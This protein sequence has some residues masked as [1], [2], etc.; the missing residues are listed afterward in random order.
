ME[1][2]RKRVA[3]GRLHRSRTVRVPSCPACNGYIHMKRD[4]KV[5]GVEGHDGVQQM[6]LLCPK[7]SHEVVIYFMNP[8]LERMRQDY[9]Q[10]LDRAKKLPS[11]LVTQKAQAKER[12]YMERFN[13]FQREMREMLGLPPSPSLPMYDAEV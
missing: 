9:R 11:T 1:R 5:R 8:Q 3:N 10:A 12:R 6:Y 4:L 13:L 7:C 2:I